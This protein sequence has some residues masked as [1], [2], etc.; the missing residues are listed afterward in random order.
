MAALEKQVMIDLA[1][2]AVAAAQRLGA[3]EAEAYVYDGQATNIGIE[4][5]Q[6]SKTNRIIDR[7]VGIRVIHSK[8]TGFAYTNIL[9]DAAAIENVAE[10]ALNAARAS[11]P[12]ADWHGLPQKRPYSTVEGTFDPRILE[13]SPQD[14]VQVTAAMLDAAG[15]VDKR[16][17]PVEGGVGSGYV[18][19]AIAN[20][21]GISVF[22]R[23]TIV[24]CSVAA[25]AKD[26]S[27]VTPVCFEFDASRIY[28]LNPEWVG[29]EA[30][31]LA[32]SALK[33]KPVD[34][35]SARVI[36]T[37]FAL[38]DLLAYTLM[39]AVKADSVQRSQSP[40]KGKIGEQ[41]ASENLTVTDDGLYPMGLRTS[42][43]DGEGVPHQKTPII[44]KGILRSFLYDNY[45][46]RKDGKEST[47]NA[48]RAGYLSTPGIET[49]NFHI[50]PQSHSAEQ[51]LSEV[52]D[53]FIVY[54]LQG[55]HSSNPVS[56][57]FSVVASPVFKVK[58][59]EVTHPCRGVMLAGNV[60]DL[61]KNISVVGGNQ[62]QMGALIAPWVVVENMRVIGK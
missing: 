17:F 22:D 31:K 10:R 48:S 47:G 37:Q 61:L 4:L 62:R 12:D 20:S 15:A 26:G 2:Q 49:S 24:E 32:V 30:A 16:V 36:L 60:F 11:R 25:L 1:Q 23:G 5:G 43:F 28:S 9:G 54:Y 34:T 7:G 14:L 42:V 44:E 45:T 8:A 39:G 35:Q 46:A 19:S 21:S 33:P 41:V 6:I 38:Q 18:S 3:A 57:E 51:M 52:G 13:L 56:G 50:P 58:G 40:F 29:K 53:G 55:A 27:S 59:G